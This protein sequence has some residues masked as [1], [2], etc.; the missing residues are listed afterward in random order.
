MAMQ[1]GTKPS[2]RA[3]WSLAWKRVTCSLRH[4]HKPYW[5]KEAA[6][7]NMPVPRPG[8][9]WF[10]SRHRYLRICAR[11]GKETSR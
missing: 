3:V 6:P 8:Q 10:L 2:F 7:E 4:G 9:G 1:T 11:C 5:L